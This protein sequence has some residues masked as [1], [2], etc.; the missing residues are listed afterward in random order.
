MTVCGV[1]LA[2]LFFGALAD[3]AEAQYFFAPAPVVYRAPV[4]VAPAPVYVSPPPV[5]YAQPVYVAPQPVGYYP[6]SF[7]FN[8]AYASSGRYRNWYRPSRGF[9]FSFGHGR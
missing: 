8:F 4:Y 5:Y 6:R 7:G 1:V 2:G 9:A 3:R